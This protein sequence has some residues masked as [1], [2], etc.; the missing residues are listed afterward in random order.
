M[1]CAQGLT[2]D[3]FT[4]LK[5]SLREHLSNLVYDRNPDFSPLGHRSAQYYIQQTLAPIGPVQHHSFCF[6]GREHI[7]LSLSVPAASLRDA[8]IMG[9]SI[10]LTGGHNRLAVE[11]SIVIGSHY[12]TVPGS[13][14]A[15]DNGSGVAVLLELARL[16]AAHPGRSPIT[17]IAFDLEEYGFVGSQAYVH[18]HLAQRPPIRLMLSLEMLGYFDTTPHSQQYPPGLKYFY[19]HRGDFIGLIGNWQTVPD[20]I[21]LRRQIRRAGS[22]CEWLPIFNAGRQFPDTRRSDHVPFWDAGYQAILVTDTA[23]LRNPHYHKASDRLETLNLDR[24]TQICWGLFC[25]LSQL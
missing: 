6:R 9:D 18:Q 5:Q 1:F 13:P 22:P 7:N 12:D 3:R 24:L 19:P 2:P 25:G 14:G 16:F 10:D 8:E 20:L 21:R 23:N 15:D 4:A 11:H 17:L